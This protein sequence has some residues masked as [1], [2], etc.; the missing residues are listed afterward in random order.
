VH[1]AKIEG[2]EREGREWPEEKAK[3]AEEDFIIIT[4][5]KGVRSEMA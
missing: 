5:G 4:F 2:E 1:S 3:G